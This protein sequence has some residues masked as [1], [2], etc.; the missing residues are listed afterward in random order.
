MKIWLIQRAEP[1]PLDADK[2]KLLRTGMLAQALSNRGNDVLWW[3][4]TFDHYRKKH[5]NGSDTF[6]DVEPGYRICMLKGT[7]YNKNIS[8]MRIVDQYAVARKFRKLSKNEQSPDVILCSLPSVELSLA[9]VEYGKVYRVPVV[10]DVRDMHPDLFVDLVPYP[11][12]ALVRFLFSPMFLKARRACAGATA[13]TG[14]T[15]AF[16]NWGIE[17]GRRVRT[18]L[19]RCFPLGH[20]ADSPVPNDLRDAEKF[21]DE[22]GVSGDGSIFVVCFIGTM[23][24]QFDIGT[25]IRAIKSNTLRC[26]VKFVVCG[27]GDKLEYYRNMAGGDKNVVF[28]GWVNAAKLY[29]LMQRSSLGLDPLPE[30]RNFLSHINNKAIE[31]MSAGLPVLSSPKRGVLFDL[32]REKRCGL[33]Y[34]YGNERELAKIITE[35][36]RYKDRLKEMSSNALK[37]FNERF[38]AEKVYTEMAEYLEKIAARGHGTE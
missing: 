1:L 32:L 21:W 23:G 14:A 3:T 10:L 27:H 11:L 30:N 12:K 19:D 9:A 6:V 38:T 22:H 24:S 26:N 15:E 29:V 5:R 17:K 25:M 2:Q 8:F 13:I 33:S 31:Y 4:S 16:V 7:G 36:A 28:A 20:T 35:L 34:E 37:L 18:E